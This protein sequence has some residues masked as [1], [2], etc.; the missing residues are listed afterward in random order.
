[1][2]GKQ[3]YALGLLRRARSEAPDTDD[4][5][6]STETF[7]DV[8]IGVAYVHWS[9]ARALRRQGL[10]EYGPYDPDYGTSIALT[11]VGAATR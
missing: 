1:V 9:T 10:I 3:S 2:T 11:D 7:F 6:V 5:V 4:G 8:E